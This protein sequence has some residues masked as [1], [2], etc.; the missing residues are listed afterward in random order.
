MSLEKALLEGSQAHALLTNP[1]FVKAYDEVEV[2]LMQRMVACPIRDKRGLYELK[3]MLKLLG[4]VKTNLEQAIGDAK[5]AEKEL[6]LLEERSKS[7]IRR[8]FPR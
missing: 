1:A 8:V 6:R 2:A 7:L 3:L 5:V 4:D